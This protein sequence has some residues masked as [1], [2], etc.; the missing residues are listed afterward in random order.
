MLRAS[1][2]PSLLS[3]GP[4]PGGRVSSPGLGREPPFGA[5][6]SPPS[7]H[8][9]KAAVEPS[10]PCAGRVHFSLQGSRPRPGWGAGA[11]VTW[12]LGHVPVVTCLWVTCEAGT[13]R[14]ED[15]LSSCSREIRRVT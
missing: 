5:H 13:G 10:F 4:V 14:D 11:R 12:S 7:A 2:K 1:G 6:P 3:V 15:V 8:A 9:G